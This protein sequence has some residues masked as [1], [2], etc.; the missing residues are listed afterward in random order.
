MFLSNP[1][2]K[3]NFV[4]AL[5]QSLATTGH[6][7]YLS[8]DDADL[9]I[10]M[11]SVEK[12]MNGNVILVGDDTDLLVLLIHHFKTVMNNTNHAMYMYRP[13]S[14]T[15]VDVRLV[16]VKWPAE[17]TEQILFIHAASGC[18]TV[19][20]MAGIGKS[21]L[22]KMIVKDDTIV[23]CSIFYENNPDFDALETIG[24]QILVYLYHA[25]SR[26]DSLEEL[27]VW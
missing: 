12:V 26:H 15:F 11:K 7:I 17:V 25:K 9:E 27:R 2:N 19:S 18:D 24:T 6:D 5:G 1:N 22:A 8:V 21:K 4:N 14:K 13:S 3:Q 16:I 23:E 20:S 10:V